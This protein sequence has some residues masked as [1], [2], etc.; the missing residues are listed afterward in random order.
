MQAIQPQIE[1]SWKIIL[2]DE[3]QKEYFAELKTFLSIRKEETLFQ[4]L[5]YV[6]LTQLK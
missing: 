1:E 2:K 4:H 5:I 6:H 3:F